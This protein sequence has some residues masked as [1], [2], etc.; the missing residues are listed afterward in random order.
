MEK[1]PGAQFYEEC[2]RPL[3][4]PDTALCLT[5]LRSSYFLTGTYT[6][7]SSLFTSIVTHLTRGFTRRM[8]VVY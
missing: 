3:L 7:L 5:Q 2:T 4:I 1:F 8:R 6:S